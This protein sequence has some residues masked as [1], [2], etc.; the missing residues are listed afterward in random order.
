MALEL[1][2]ASIREPESSGYFSIVAVEEG[3]GGT[4]RLGYLC[5]GPTPM[6]DWT[7]DLYWV[8][9]DPKFRGRRVGFHLTKEFEELV[10]ARKGRII[11]VETA[12]HES[13]GGT[14]DFYSKTGYQV[15]SRIPDFYRAGDDLITLTKRFE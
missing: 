7:Y 1:I 5:Y 6:T 10:K 11:R 9:V 14:L 12:S 4:D 2:D 3:D 13:Y 8:A 15:I